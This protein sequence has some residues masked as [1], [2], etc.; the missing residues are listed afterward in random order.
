MLIFAPNNEKF[1]G[2]F[3]RRLKMYFSQLPANIKENFITGDGKM[4][5]SALWVM[6]CMFTVWVNGTCFAETIY[7][8]QSGGGDY[9]SI[10]V[11]INAAYADDI[12]KVG[13]GVYNENVVIDK[14]L[15]LIGSGPNF[16]TI[17]SS[18][19]SI[20]VNANL[21]VDISGFSLTSGEN[22]IHLNGDYIHAVIENCLIT[23]CGARG[24]RFTGQDSTISIFNNSILS[25]GSSGILIYATTGYNPDVS[26][27][28]QGNIIAFNGRYGIKVY[29]IHDTEVSSYNDVF[30]NTDL[31][32][33]S[34]VAGIG[35]ISEN[36]K[37]I[38]QNNGNYVLRSDSPCKDTGRSGEMNNDPDGTRNDMGA[39]SGAGAAAFWPYVP[40]GPVITEMSVTPASVPK[41]GKITIKAKGRVQ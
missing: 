22:G 3:V 32:Y 40:G 20:L 1:T 10:Q 15:E 13:P 23:G 6:V 2:G 18:A 9:T 38:D 24:I 14:N 31:N 28:I 16:T 26:V 35:D 41:G 19:D 25:N 34:C 11:G 39:Y 36:P 5:K 17:K 21:N 30:S 4:K 8:D 12:I 37:F 33:V 7:V 27:S 29:D